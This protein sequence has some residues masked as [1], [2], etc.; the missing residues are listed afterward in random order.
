MSLREK[1]GASLLEIREL[2]QAQTQVNRVL[3][4][5]RGMAGEEVRAWRLKD[6]RNS[7]YTASLVDTADRFASENMALKKCLEEAEEARRASGAEADA[8]VSDLE[9]QVCFCL[10]CYI[11]YCLLVCSVP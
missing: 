6:K 7:T 9:E 3:V 1:L 8:R 5:T 2:R 4:E 11:L 10:A